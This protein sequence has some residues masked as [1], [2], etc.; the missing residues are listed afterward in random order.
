MAYTIQRGE[1]IVFTVDAVAIECLKQSDMA[2]SADKIDTTCKNAAGTTSSEIGALTT[3]FSLS[4]NYTEGTGSNKDFHNLW[5]L[6]RA[7]TSF[8]G[9]WGG[10]DTGD[11]T[12][13]GTCRIMSLNASAGNVGSLVEWTAEVEVSDDITVATVS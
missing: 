10:V 4:G 12:Y 3:T 7:R 13:S 8:T 6:H 11:K 2:S 5:T 9:K 1:S